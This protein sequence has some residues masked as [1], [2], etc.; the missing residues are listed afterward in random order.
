MAAGSY[1]YVIVG[2]GS[3]GCVL[4]GRLSA[5]P[6]CRVALLEAGGSDRKREIRIPAGFTKLFLTGY[7]WNY[8]TSKQP[9][10]S[11][12]ELYWPRGKTLGGSSSIHGQAW[13]RGHR[14]DYDGW[15]ESCPGW[16]YEEVLPYFQR[17]EHRVGS[18]IGEVYGTSG[19]QFI[20]ELR[21]PN[22]TT[23]AFLAG[24]AELGMRRLGELNEPDNTGYAPTPVTQRRGLRHSAADAYL[25]PARRR[26]NLT[27]LTGALAQRILLDGVRAT[28]VKYRDAA[29]VTQLVTASREVIISAGTINS[30]QLLMLSGIGERDQLRAAGVEPRHELV[31]VGANLQ[32]HLACGVIVHCP[33]PVTLFAADSPAQL[34]R[35]LLARRGMLTSSVNEAVAFVRSDAALAAPDLEL[36]WLPVPLLGEGLIPPPAHGLTLGVELLQPDSYGDIRLASADPAEPPVIDPGYLTAQSDL[37]GLVAGLRIAER[38]LDT[39]ALR[40]YVGAPM[41]PW[42]GNVDDAKLATYVR[43]HAQTAFHPVGTCR[44][45]SDDAAVVDCEL[46][47]RGLDGLRVVDASVMPRITRGHTHAPT[48]MIA[49]RAADLIRAGSHEPEPSPAT[50]A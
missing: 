42:P 43:E 45:G 29:G 19:P 2:A 24:C 7:D 3:A 13:T 33:K 50:A 48:V 41:A 26:R 18:N 31:G 34:A 21:D 12:R 8:R 32:D 38:L 35:L 6:A 10:L 28:G 15:A 11:D 40:P 36:V 9:Q 22:P 14:V 46:R 37:R 16:S 47:V 30:P 23:S 27:V 25:R 44:M 49:E 4:A 1:H 39:A 20:S 17:A 5:D